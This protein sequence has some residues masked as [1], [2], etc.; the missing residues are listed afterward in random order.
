MYGL[1]LEAITAETNTRAQ[2]QGRSPV[3]KIYGGILVE[4][5]WK[6]GAARR[7]HGADQAIGYLK[8]IETKTGVTGAFTAVV[9]DGREW[10]FLIEHPTD[11]LDLFG[12]SPQNPEDNFEWRP[13]SAASCRRFL[14]LCGSHSRSPVTG[15][16]LAT[17]FGPTNKNVQNFVSLLA[18]SLSGRTPGSRTDTLLHEW[19][20]STEIA[21][22]SLNSIHADLLSELRAAFNVPAGV[23][24][25]LEELLFVIH[26]YFALVARLVAV[27]VLAIALDEHDSQPSTWVSYDDAELVATMLDFDAGNIPR[28]LTIENLFESD[29]FSWYVNILYGD[30]DLLTALRQVL[31]QLAGFAFPQVAY[32][33]HRST[34]NLRELYQRLIPRSLRKLLG[35]FLTPYWLAEACLSR[36]AEHGAPLNGGRILDPTCGTGTFLLPLLRTRVAALRSSK[37][38]HITSADVQELL[39]G[40]AGFDINPIAVTATRANFIVALGSLAEVGHFHL[41]VWRTDSLVVPEPQPGQGQ[42]SDPRLIGEDIVELQTSLPDPFP[43][44]RSITNS[45]QVAAVRVALETAIREPNA[46]SGLNLFIEELSAVL[47]PETGSVPLDIDS[48]RWPRVIGILEVLY[49]RVRTLADAGRNGVWA[50]IIENAFAP[51]F[52]GRFDVVVG[53]PPWLGW[54]KLPERWRQQ[55]EKLWKRFGLW[56]VPRSPGETRKHLAQFNDIATLVYATA[57]ARYAADGGYVGFLTPEALTIADPGARAFRKFHLQSEAGETGVDVRFEIL[58]CDNWRRIKPFGAD[59]AN[60]PIF[61]IARRDH[62]QTFPVPTSQ[63]ERAAVGGRIQGNEWT[64]VRLQL[65]EIRGDSYPVDRSRP[66][67]AWS[68][69]PAGASLLEGGTNE[70]SFGMGANARGAAGIYMLRS[71]RPTM[72]PGPSG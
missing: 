51:L 44:P 2:G 67:S 41:P 38:V 31:D 18:A 15:I 12:K 7:R 23:S 21:Y 45:S 48:D 4:Y 28:A 37:G 55:A 22:G 62:D 43:I 20:R 42:L 52:S 49:E 33:A 40:F 24:Q 61:L 50:R 64:R 3:D 25:S 36:L 1:P 54:P 46:K 6:M 9:T 8:G 35:E 29:V 19:E 27:E 60:N 16:G 14:Q 68:F 34:D 47:H 39:D 13:N 10:G 70:W 57:L 5:E 71:R 26:T 66:Y 65:K 11:Q 32:G 56:S 69:V 53:N 72:L 30:F 17:A 63:W 58:S 59:A